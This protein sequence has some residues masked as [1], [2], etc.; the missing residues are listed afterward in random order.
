MSRPYTN[1]LLQAIEE[2]YID[3][4]Y[5]VK[6]LLKWMSEDEVKEFC[7]NA[8]CSGIASELA[9]LAAQ[10]NYNHTEELKDYKEDY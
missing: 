3:N 6:S 7:L 8:E 9:N 4:E 1:I 2:E 10:D 5:I